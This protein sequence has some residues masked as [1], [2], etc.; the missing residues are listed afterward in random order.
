MSVGSGAESAG[1]MASVIVATHERRAD[2][3]ETLDALGRVCAGEDVEVIVVANACTDGTVEAARARAV[4]FPASLTVIDEPR[5]GLSLARNRG[6][7]AA[8]GSFFVFID[9]DISPDPTWLS[10]YREA[11]ADKSVLA[12]GGP[13]RTRLLETADPWIARH[14]DVPVVRGLLGHYDLGEAPVDLGASDEPSFPYGGNLAV[15]G[16]VPE[17]QGVFR[18]DLGYGPSGVPG[19]ETDYLRRITRAG[20]VRYAP[21]ASVVHRIQPE[22]QTRQ[23]F[24]A[25]QTR[26]GR[27]DVRS[28]EPR[29][30]LRRQFE[31]L[32]L[33][34]KTASKARS[35]RNEDDPVRVARWARRR[36]RLLELR[37]EAPMKSP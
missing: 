37:G 2:L 35:I 28:A 7:E 4:D 5:A 14:R 1:V 13:I 26:Q 34:W 32:R 33:W 21:R 8:R 31:A 11:F 3:M 9:D 10:A 17:T 15:R 25:Y 16:C 30:G 20:I 12:A 6:I 18:E 19:E 23:S 36:G 22:K 29:R 24:L 27:L